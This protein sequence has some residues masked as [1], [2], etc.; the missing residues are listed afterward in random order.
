MSSTISKGKGKAI[1]ALA[2]KPMRRSINEN[3]SGSSS[4]SSSSSSSENELDSSDDPSDSDSDFGSVSPE[5]LES[6]LAKAKESMAAKARE[7][8]AL[9]GEEDEIRLPDNANNEFPPL[10][11]GALPPSYF[12]FD[13][14][15]RGAPPTVRDV[16][17]DQLEK[18][19]KSLAIPAP[20]VEVSKD[21]KKLLK[22]QRKAQ[23]EKTAGPGWF[24]LPA[25]DAADLPRLY[26]EAEA[27]RL[28]NT[29]DPKRF[30]RKE[31]GEGKGI[32]GLPKYF[33]IGTILPTSTPFGTASNDNLSRA[34]RK[35]TIV[36][37]LVDDSEAKR[38][39]KK[40]FEDLQAVRGAKGKGTLAQRKAA[41]RMKW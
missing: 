15:R 28:R 36:D 16:D 19:S 22:K 30:Y 6:L 37:E 8:A 18:V 14:T 32:K 25:P 23:K 11:P 20:A 39:A 21:G 27:L 5:Y 9:T 35:R 2:S 33:A 4:S 13:T 3:A 38:Y 7:K 26:R 31:E 10:D 24:D 29:L 40:K 41:R 1:A 34:D 12:E 17:A